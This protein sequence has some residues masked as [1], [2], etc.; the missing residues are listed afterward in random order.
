MGD[1]FVHPNPLVTVTVYV[2]APRLLK[3]TGVPFNVVPGGF[4]VKEM[5]KVTA[6]PEAIISP[7]FVPLHVTLVGVSEIVGSGCTVIFN[8]SFLGGQLP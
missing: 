5:G 1:V 6:V 4:I 8:V 3:L 7:V 2:P